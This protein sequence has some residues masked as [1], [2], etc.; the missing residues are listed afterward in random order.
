[1]RA[2]GSKGSAVIEQVCVTEIE[3][4]TLKR[5]FSWWLNTG[6]DAALRVKVKCFVRSHQR[7]DDGLRALLRV[8]STQ[9]NGAEGSSQVNLFHLEHAEKPEAVFYWGRRGLLG[10]RESVHKLEAGG[11][12][13]SGRDRVRKT[14]QVM[15]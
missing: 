5:R 10:N 1:M 6:S 13:G 2:S 8:E 4:A 15:K 12:G 3:P 14:R 11:D 9:G 7:G